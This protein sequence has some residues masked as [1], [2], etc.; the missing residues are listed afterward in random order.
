MVEPTESQK[1]V[2]HTRRRRD[3]RS[4]QPATALSRRQLRDREQAEAEAEAQHRAAAAQAAA[5]LS[6]RERR[7][8]E[9]EER[10]S[11]RRDVAATAPDAAGAPRAEV[12]AEPVV[13][14][15]P[16]PAVEAEPVVEA[17]PEPDPAVEA[18]L[19]EEPELDPAPAPVAP[20]SRRAR[21]ARIET[22]AVDIENTP[23]IE[24]EKTPVVESEKTPVV[25]DELVA[26]PS[27]EPAIDERMLAVASL[28]T[29]P[30]EIELVAQHPLVE[31]ET[32]E[33]IAA[34][35]VMSA[36]VDFAE[37]HV[38]AEP[39]T[40]STEIDIIATHAAPEAISALATSG[41][42]TPV[43]PVPI[44]SPRIKRSLPV[45]ELLSSSSG[46]FVSHAR[47][48]PIKR[49]ILAGFVMMIAALFVVSISIPSLGF[50][51]TSDF[52]TKQTPG[53]VTDSQNLS[54]G[55]GPALN[56]VRDD[57]YAEGAPGSLYSTTNSYVSKES[58]KLA[59]ELMAAVAAG[60]L[61]G[62]VPDH[63]PEIQALADG[64]VKPDCGIDLR[65][66][67]VMVIAVRTF[68]TVAVSDIN[69]K[70]TNQI[71]GAGT[72]S[73]HYTNGGGHAVDFYLINGASLPGADPNTIKFA[74][75]LDPI[76]PAGSNLGQ[77][78]CRASAGV[79]LNLVNFKEFPDSCTHMHIDVG[80]TTGALN[81]NLDRDF[82]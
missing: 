62:S 30:L 21:R 76:M 61:K 24:V 54:V 3:S 79:S 17:D 40:M 2:E 58:Q 19:V 13:A 44:A 50:A 48:Q 27:V 82:K 23:A 14:P 32:A 38:A 20:T 7:E 26:E 12:A 66:L 31:I 29:V 53:D 1:N 75:L 80:S 37:H 41:D 51:S 73:S 59:Q 34:E 4:A 71:E 78:E 11:E 8:R 47:F 55:E 64:V 74:E 42:N 9:Y 28:E 45:A 25:E 36:E 52:A 6:R 33:H 69:R 39:T 56:A 57:F 43:R 70:C 77:S 63:I 65:I 16:E 68:D 15:E 5:G 46:T 72:G 22:P 49:R 18:V 60:K 67:Q 81:V 35:T 10:Y